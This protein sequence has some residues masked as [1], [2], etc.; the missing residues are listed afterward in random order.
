[1]PAAATPD[2]DPGEALVGQ[3]IKDG[4]NERVVEFSRDIDETRA[5]IAVLRGGAEGQSWQDERFDA[6]VFAG[7][8]GGGQAGG[9]NEPGIVID[10]EVRS[11]LLGAAGRDH[12]EPA[13][14]STLADFQVGEV[15]KSHGDALLFYRYVRSPQRLAAV[16]RWIRA[17]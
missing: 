15:T 10:W 9:F 14:P 6:V 4:A 13:A 3:G 7:A 5:V 16:P 12:G 17:D 1:M 2:E 8:F 11:L